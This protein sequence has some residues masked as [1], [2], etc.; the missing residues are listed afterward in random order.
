MVKEFFADYIPLVTYAIVRG[1]VI[2]VIALGSVYI[3][4]RMFNVARTYRVKNFV[5]LVVMVGTSYWS[6]LMYDMEI[7][8]HPLEVYWRTL[9][10]VAVASVLYVLAGFD[11]YD[12]F[13]NWSDKKFGK[14]RT[15]TTD[16]DFEEPKKP[17]RRSRKK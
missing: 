12:R 2:F 5:A 15:R 14:P 17:T 6:V 7:I 4:G 13:N 1:L 3:V 16:K 8:V 10:Y 9:V 11:L